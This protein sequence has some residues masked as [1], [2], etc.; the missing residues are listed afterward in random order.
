MSE[1]NYKKIGYNSLL[2]MSYEEAIHYLLNKYGEV[3]DDYFKEKSYARFLRGEIKTITKGK[4]SKTSEGLYC[5]HIYEN[6]YE[7][8]SSLYYINC[9]KYPFKYQ[10]KE[11][12]VYCDLFEHLILHALIIKETEAEYGLHGY[13]EYLYPIAIDWFLNETDPKPEWMKKCKERAYLNQQD[14]EKIINKIHEIISPFKEARSAM[15]EEEYKKSIKKNIASKLGMTVSEYEEY[16]VQ[17]EKEAKKRLKLEE[18]ER[19][20]E[21]NKKYPNLQKINVN[22][23]TP[24]KK[25]LNFLYEL[26]YSK[27]FPKRKDFYKAKISLIGVPSA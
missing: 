10:K 7:N 24:R 1:N 18:L 6:K 19:L 5:H 22:N 27:D 15:L 9:F 25:I 13:E 8:I 3:S 20:N 4:Y 26:A 14:A 2:N 11:S 17:E 16:L 12:L 21:F 23:T